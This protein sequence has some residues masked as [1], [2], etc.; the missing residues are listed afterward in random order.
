MKNKHSPPH[1]PPVICR[2]CREKVV[3]VDH[4]LA[5]C[6]AAQQARA[7]SQEHDKVHRLNNEA[8]IASM[9]RQISA[10]TGAFA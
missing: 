6:E 8:F 3:A 10:K 1:S 9:K 4:T 2:R 7:I 5:A